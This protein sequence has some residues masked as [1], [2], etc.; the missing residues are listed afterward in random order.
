MDRDSYKQLVDELRVQKRNGKKIAV[1]FGL[2]G[3]NQRL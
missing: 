3:C 2:K 1:I